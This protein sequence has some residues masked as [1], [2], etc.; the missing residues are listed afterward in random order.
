MPQGQGGSQSGGYSPVAADLISIANTRL[1]ARDVPG[2]MEAMSKFMRIDQARTMRND[3]RIRDMLQRLNRD[4]RDPAVNVWPKNLADV[5]VAL[6]KLQFNEP[7]VIELLETVADIAKHRMDRFTPHDMTCIAWGFA[8]LSVRNE[9]LMSVLAAEV[10]NKIRTF[11]QRHLSNTAWA[12]AKCGLWNAQLVQLITEESLVKISTFTA[13]SLGHISWAMAHWGARNS[14]MMD[15]IAQEVQAKISDFSP[16]PLAMTAWSFSSLQIRNAQLFEVISQDTIAKISDCTTQDLAHLAWAYANLLIHDPVLFSVMASEIERT[17]E[18]AQPPQLANIAWA[19]SKVDIKAEPCMVAVADVAVHQIRDFKPAELAMLTW[20]FAVAGVRVKPLMQE[21]GT[22]VSQRIDTYTPSQLSNI[23]WAFGSLLLRH[24][25][26]L[27]TLS[28]HM[29][30]SFSAFKAQGLTNIV[31]AFAMVSYHDEPLLRRTAPRIARDAAEL[32]PFPLARCAWAYQLFGVPNPQV[33]AAIS[34]EAIKKLDKFPT[35]ALMKLVD[36]LY[37]SPAAMELRRLERALEARVAQVALV[38]RQTWDPATIFPGREPENYSRT[39]QSFGHV[40]CGVVGTPMLLSQLHVGVP[41][42]DFMLQVRTRSWVADI[43]DSHSHR[44]DL[45]SRK[46]A[47]ARAD[48]CFEDQSLN[49][50]LTSL[51]CHSMGAD[52][53]KK[54]WLVAVDFL[55]SRPARLECAF[56]VLSDLCTRIFAMGVDPG[57]LEARSR[58]A[59]SVQ[60]HSNVIPCLSTIGAIHQFNMLFQGV[61][62]YFAEQVT[63]AGKPSQINQSDMLS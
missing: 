7:V 4:L 61:A 45:S 10:V 17:I 25:V 16:M 55:P 19:Y 57:S 49:T 36:S 5:S 31:W 8:S 24:C 26:F 41:G 39:L 3:L 33:L 15:A 21:I 34:V 32:R 63:D 29:E 13:N 52:V 27:Q 30:T 2:A 6:G 51:A 43:R 48:I 37:V 11:D 12:F 44:W 60:M 22:Q 58:V 53:A 9:P 54:Q 18:G 42:R 47:V 50:W 1:E 28:A 38:L 23:A 56:V 20:A 59:G 35:K 40:D 46:Y 62:V 14:T